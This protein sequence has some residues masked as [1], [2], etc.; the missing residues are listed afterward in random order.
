MVEVREMT[1]YRSVTFRLLPGS[2]TRAQKLAALAGACRFV[3]NEM[4]DQQDQLHAA[5][6]LCGAKAPAPTFFTL[7]KAFTQLRAVT[8]WLQEMPFGPVRYALKYQADAWA[9]FF[10]GHA[11]RPRF[12]QRGNDS[13]TIPDN[14]RIRDGMLHVP[15]IGKVSLRRR[16]GNPY[17]DAEPVR[18]VL[19]RV[20][21]KWYATVC[22]RVD[23]PERPD[24]GEVVGLDMNVRQ[25]ADSEGRIHRAPDTRR[26]EARRRRYQRKLA[27]QRRGS[28]RREKTRRRL[29]RAQRRIAMRRRDWQHHVSLRLSGGTVVVEDIKP[30]AMT[31]SATGTAKAPG[32]N[33]KAKAGLN[34]E[35]LATGWA[36]LRAMLAYK[37]PRVIAVN[38]AH[39][40][41]TCHACGVADAASRRGRRFECV[42]CGHADHADV[43][44]ARNIRRRGLAL[45]HGEGRS[46]LPTPGTRETDRGL[47]A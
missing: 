18:A 40:S 38:P 44:A 11:A 46:D 42:A 14:I 31:A 6:L 15:R 39:T 26:L 33:V 3:W 37:A 7:G 12:K 24:S 4:L 47:A 35:I 27:R 25:V 9:A 17:A 28:K 30:R 23:V 5:A 19:K 45:L 32:R 41:L 29:A 13:V 36:E 10:R 20:C 22:Y 34:R 43:N 2:R 16:G 1:E 8:P 21:G